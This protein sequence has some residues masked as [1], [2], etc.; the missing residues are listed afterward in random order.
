MSVQ[1]LYLLPGPRTKHL[2]GAA[3]RPMPRY[4]QSIFQY[5][6]YHHTTPSLNPNLNL[7]PSPQPWPLLAAC[8]FCHLLFVFAIDSR[9]KAKAVSVSIIMVF[10]LFQESHRTHCFA[11]RRGFPGIRPAVSLLGGV[12][13][14]KCHKLRMNFKSSW[15]GCCLSYSWKIYGY[16]FFNKM[17]RCSL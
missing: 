8:S 3:G 13:N 4:C 10:N 2:R 11:T 17:L 5:L 16:M 14:W 9:S 7:S 12:P 15:V 1:Y 6:Q